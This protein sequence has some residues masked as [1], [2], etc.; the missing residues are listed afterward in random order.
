MQSRAELSGAPLTP[1]YGP[2][3]HPAD[4]SRPVD[5]GG[6]PCYHLGVSIN[7]NDPNTW[8][9]A[10]RALFR[11]R[12]HVTRGRPEL[13]ALIRER[14][15]AQGPLSFAEFMRLALYHPAHGYYIAP[16]LRFGREGDFL[17]APETHPAFGALVCRFLARLWAQMG[18][19]ARFTVVEAGAG[20]G[21]LAAQIWRYAAEHHP[22]LAAALEYLVVETSPSLR[23]R[24][25]RALHALSAN[26]RWLE[27]LDEVPPGS[28]EGCLLT[29]ELL[30]A[31]PVHRVQMT[32]RG[33][34]ELYVG[35][36]DGEFADLPGPLSTPEIA[37]FFVHV[38]VMPPEGTIAE[39]GLEAVAWYRQAAGCLARGVLLT[40]DYGYPATE[41]YTPAR[42]RGTLLCYYRH[43]ANEEPYRRIGTQDITAHVDLT[44]L[45]RAGEEAGLQTR[46]LQTQREWL[47]S[48]GIEEWLDGHGSGPTREW[49]RRD[50]VA[51]VHPGALGRL[52]VLVQAKGL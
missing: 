52:K 50:L 25:Q 10:A 5:S 46:A 14:I 16:D 3:P 43:A 30:D 33:L 47:H 18:A 4:T 19:P 35:L 13:V 31:L 41:L 12:E 20:T 26:A 27:S 49:P 44:A 17:T 2:A 32:D 11:Q 42:P 37:R 45:T 7:P 48:L 28:V 15:E 6:W 1:A 39:V 29:N 9:E 8:P 34:Q 23:A 24:Q 40:I 36:R 21:A 51:L 22:N 38:G